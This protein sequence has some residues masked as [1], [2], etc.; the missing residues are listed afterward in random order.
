MKAYL[1][2]KFHKDM[3]NRELIKELSGILK[4]LGIESSIIVRDFESWGGNERD[5]KVLMAKAFEEIDRSDAVIIELSEKGVGLGIEA[6]YAAA[7]GKPIWVVA[8]TGSDI[9]NTLS[10]IA[11]KILFYNKPG[12]LTPQIKRLMEK[13]N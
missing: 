13:R 7:K 3:R 12:D 2:I 8:K 11:E 10:G 6:G 5:P 4:S 1:G 9:S